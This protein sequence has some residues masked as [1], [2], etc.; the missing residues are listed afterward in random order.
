MTARIE[1]RVVVDSVRGHSVQFRMTC[2][3]CGRHGVWQNNLSVA[4]NTALVHE[5]SEHPRKESA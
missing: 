3:V 4:E 1:S 5:R 2:S